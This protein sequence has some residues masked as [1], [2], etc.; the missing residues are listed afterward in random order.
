MVKSVKMILSEYNN[1]MKPFLIN[2]DDIEIGDMVCE[3]LTTG[4][5]LPMTIQ[6]IN[7]LD[8]SK[9]KKVIA[10][11]EQL[12]YVVCDNWVTNELGINSYDC[13]IREIDST[14]V[15]TI[16]NNGG[17]CKIEMITYEG[18]YCG[19]RTIKYNNNKV[20]IHI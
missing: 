2:D 16:I 18:E 15:D 11:P 13:N 3:L 9:Q 12:G 10:I 7:D 6:T 19:Y 1:E 14:D 5:W 8:K 4:N 20:L 17:N